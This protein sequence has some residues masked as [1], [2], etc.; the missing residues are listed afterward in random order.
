V[1]DVEYFSYLGSMITSD[2][3]C[4]REIKSR[5]AMEKA[6][7]NMKKT[8][9][10]S[11]LD[12]KL[13]KKLVKYYIWSTAVYGTEKWT[14]RKVDQTYL[15]S[16]KMW[17]WRRMEKIIWTNRVKEEEVLHRDKEVRNVLHKIKKKE[18]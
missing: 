9:F 18:G 16:L 15:K 11:K 13:R 6:A 7:F 2:A 1:T 14:L 10:T 8:H 17:C 4:K 12:L 3:K 5:I